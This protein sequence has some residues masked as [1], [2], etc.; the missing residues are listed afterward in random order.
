MAVNGGLEELAE[1]RTGAPWNRTK[2]VMSGNRRKTPFPWHFACILVAAWE[3][4]LHTLNFSYSALRVDWL[5]YRAPSAKK[6]PFRFFLQAKF[7][8][9][10]STVTPRYFS[11]THSAT[12]SF[13]R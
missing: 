3:G 1:A 11:E 13:S 6:V 8:R 12:G 9:F 4:Q 2:P 7:A 5:M 10:R